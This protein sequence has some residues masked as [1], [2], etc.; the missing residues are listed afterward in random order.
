MKSAAIMLRARENDLRQIPDA[1][2]SIS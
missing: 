2:R 1:A